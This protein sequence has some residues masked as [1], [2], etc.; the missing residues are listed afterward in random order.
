MTTEEKAELTTRLRAMLQHIEELDQFICGLSN[1][2][3]F[4]RDEDT[5]TDRIG[6]RMLQVKEEIEYTLRTRVKFLING[7]DLFA[8]FP[9][10]PFTQDGEKHTYF[11]SY[12]RIGQHSACTPE[13]A[14]E[15]YPATP[16][17]YAA[18]KEELESIGYELEIV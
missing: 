11:T 9:E 2:N 1:S 5:R 10:E 13:Y 4:T 15:S 18:L 17:E 3:K 14:A 6:R 12:G 7:D 8:Y 16:Q